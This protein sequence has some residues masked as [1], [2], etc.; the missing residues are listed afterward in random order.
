[1]QIQK[2]FDAA[3]VGSGAAGGM[4][5]HDLALAGLDVLMLEAGR[6]YDP[7]TETAM[8]QTPEDAPLRGFPTDD[9]PAGYYDATVNG[10]WSVPGEPYVVA[11][12][13]EP[14]VWWRPRM[15]GGRTNHWG[16]VSLR[17]GPY[18][19]KPKSRD[20]LGVD[21]PITYEEIAP[22]YDKVEALI[23]VTGASEGLENSPDSP[24]GNAVA[25]SATARPRDRARQSL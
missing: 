16:R 1:M 6:N 5:A 11:K 7:Q 20:G 22:W 19:F 24:E 14:F 17:F 2:E 15:L 18:D 3:I 13:S 12:G 4:V 9:K 25:A 10:G 23:G 8:F 21:W